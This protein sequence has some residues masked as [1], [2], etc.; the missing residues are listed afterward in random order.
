MYNNS[1]DRAQRVFIANE[2]SKDRDI[3]ENGKEN[4]GER[5]TR[6]FNMSKRPKIKIYLLFIVIL[7]FNLT[8]TFLDIE[9]E[10]D[11]HIVKFPVKCCQNGQK[12]FTH[13]IPCEYTNVPCVDSNHVYSRC[14]GGVPNIPNFTR[15]D[16]WQLRA[17]K[18]ISKR[19]EAIPAHFPRNI[20]LHPAS[21]APR[22]YGKHQE[23]GMDHYKAQ[24]S[25]AEVV[26]VQKNPKKVRQ[27]KEKT[28][29]QWKDTVKPGKSLDTHRKD[30][31]PKTPRRVTWKNQDTQ[32]NHKMSKDPK[33]PWWARMP[34]KKVDPKAQS[35]PGAK[36]S[37]PGRVDGTSIECSIPLSRGGSRGGYGAEDLK[38][39]TR[40]IRD[41]HG[42]KVQWAYTCGKCGKST[43]EFGVKATNWLQNHLSLQHGIH[44]EHRFKVGK[45]L[46]KT[47]AKILERTAPSL[48]N[49]RRIMTSVNMM[50]RQM[51]PE[52]LEG[53]IQ[54]RMVMPS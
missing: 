18:W 21:L 43:K 4:N 30:V 36:S 19:Q 28:S 41:A 32:K 10:V 49:P 38:Y 26:T 52:K 51:T 3:N 44:V 35:K 2:S 13:I 29:S 37:A 20:D 45:G 14:V 9:K 16:N 17:Q 27:L 34:L 31:K 24:R 54:A 8:G 1:K 53:M 7:C 46:K 42:M 40:H 48:S 6:R 39:L 25:Y 12:E 15:D 50:N 23:D 33:T 5:M 22:G 47:N 11:V